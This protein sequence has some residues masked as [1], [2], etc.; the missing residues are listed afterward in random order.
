MTESSSLLTLS[1]ASVA[2][3]IQRWIVDG[4]ER[5]QLDV[6]DELVD[7][8]A[9]DRGAPVDQTGSASFK[10][11]A[12]ALHDAFSAITSSVSDDIVIDR[13]ELR[14]AWRFT[15]IGT[16]SASFMGIDATGRRVTMRGM[17]IQ[18]LSIDMR[19]IEHFT[20]IDRMSIRD[21]L[22]A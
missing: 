9:I 11:R 10:Q 8:D 13:E 15:L 16:H 7:A 12:R 19:V 3:F 2:A 1:K 4:I 22:L 20:M 14:I 21:Q 17:N 6:F 5:G 18:R